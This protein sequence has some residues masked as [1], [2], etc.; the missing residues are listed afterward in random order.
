MRRRIAILAGFLT[1]AG[2]V[3]WFNQGLW[4]NYVELRRSEQEERQRMQ[5]AEEEYVKALEDSVKVGGAVGR[6]EIARE[7]GYVRKGEE[8][9]EIS[10]PQRR[11]SSR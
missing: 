3:A 10:Q 8:P 1:A 11:K 7:R 4:K 9:L 2:V 5:A 6:E